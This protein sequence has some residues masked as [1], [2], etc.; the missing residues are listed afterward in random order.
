MMSCTKKIKK[1]PNELIHLFITRGVGTGK[2][3]T[4]MILIQILIYFFTID[5]FN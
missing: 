5:I 4:L 3:F 2:T 1:N